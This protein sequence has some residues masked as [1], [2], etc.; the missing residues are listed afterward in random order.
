MVGSGAVGPRQSEWLVPREGTVVGGKWVALV[1]WAGGDK[2]LELGEGC[3]R[4]SSPHWESVCGGLPDLPL[5]VPP[6][7]VGRR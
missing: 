2:N 1:T 4:P 3:G 5:P 7:D 6:W